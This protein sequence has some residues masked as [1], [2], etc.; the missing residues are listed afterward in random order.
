MYKAVAILSLLLFSHSTYSQRLCFSSDRLHTLFVQC[1][2]NVQDYQGK[3][4]DNI[5]MLQG[6][7][8]PLVVECTSTCVSH[9]GID[10]FH[11]LIREENPLI[12]RFVERY[13]LE[14]TM[15]PPGYYA[16]ERMKKDGVVINGDVCDVLKISK[17]DMVVIYKELDAQGKVTILDADKKS[18][19]AIHFPLVFDFISGMDKQ[20]ADESFIKELEAYNPID[21]EEDA[22]TPR[23][24]RVGKR[25]YASENGY[26]ESEAVQ[27]TAFYIRSKGCYRPVCNSAYPAESIMTLLTGHVIDRD[28]RVQLLQHKYGYA[29]SEASIPLINLIGFCIGQG[30]TPYVGIESIDDKTVKASLFMVNSSLGYVHTFS[31]DIPKKL[32][33]SKN[34]I[35]NASVYTYTPIRY[36]D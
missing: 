32:L 33:D 27:N 11:P 8:F 7:A 19:F 6:G 26:Y 22:L 30:C 31:F 18:I 20:E 15:L 10:L 21:K 3:E 14:I 1:G 24:S 12:Y 16:A 13:L 17:Q 4:K 36:K 9:I 35:L 34:G 28:Y 5:T 25:L 2:L 23:L 29:T